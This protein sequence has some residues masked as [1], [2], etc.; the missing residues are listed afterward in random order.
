MNLLMIFLLLSKTL[1]VV[2]SILLEYH[3][4]VD[5]VFT[6]YKT[7][8]T[9]ISGIEKP[10]STIFLI[11]TQTIVDNDEFST[12]VITNVKR[13]DVKPYNEIAYNMLKNLSIRSK[14]NRQGVSS[15]AETFGTQFTLLTD[16]GFPA[17]DIQV[18]D[19]WIGDSGELYKTNC[20]FVQ[21]DEN[22]VATIDFVSQGIF[23]LFS[24][25]LPMKTSGSLK[26]D[27]RDGVTV[28]RTETKV[29]EYDSVIMVESSLVK[30]LYRMPL[31]SDL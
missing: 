29:Y 22:A 21:L 14:V 18:G 1:L 28:E 2:N 20:T 4:S 23:N 11:Y 3:P 27:T 10:T 15:S 31:N 24:I 30:L 9:G 25:Q 16:A 19:S 13:T 8:I 26:I 7:Q 12:T 17:Y 5:D 6:Y